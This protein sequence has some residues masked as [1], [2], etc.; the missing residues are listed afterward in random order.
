MPN[1][2]NAWLRQSLV[3]ALLAVAFGYGFASSQY[4]IFPFQP[5][6]SLY[7]SISGAL[8]DRKE[9]PDRPAA[10]KVNS[11]RGTLWRD[12]SGQTTAQQLTE[13]QRDAIALLRTIGYA[14][15]SQPGPAGSGVLVFDRDRS[16]GG[17]NLWWD[18]HAAA[19]ILMDMDGNELHRWSLP[20]QAAFPERLPVERADRLPFHTF[21][22]RIRLLENGDLL[23][24]Y[25]GQGLVKIDSESKLLWACPCLAHHDL[26]VTE[27]GSIY[28]L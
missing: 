14:S 16:Y 12:P 15:G 6:R 28:V 27:D 24:I 5:I 17:L 13:E 2:S 26:D 11:E 22:R 23:A 1:S 19:A 10:W 7:R 4:R 3:L 8:T 9:T 25:E 21:W 20:I 18:G